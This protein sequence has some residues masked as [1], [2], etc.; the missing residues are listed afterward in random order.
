[1]SQYPERFEVLM[2]GIAGGSSEEIRHA[3]AEM[4]VRWKD[5]PVDALLSLKEKLRRLDMEH[6]E[7]QVDELL[8]SI[9]EKRPGPF[10]EIAT[11]PG[12]PLWRAS[13][14]VLTMV[15]S[16]EYLDLFVSLLPLCRKKG[17]RD[18]V[19]A[20]GSFKG[21]KVVEALGPYLYS[22]DRDTFLEAALALKR[23]GGEKALYHLKGCFEAKRRG[24][25]EDASI[26]EDLIAD[27]GQA[28]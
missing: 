13:V 22:E 27:M 8:I 7:A 23:T 28:A 16:A 2:E 18:I 1:M 17:L 20:I 5:A 19:K 9:A 14:E 3:C 6:R 10:T 12:H 4:R 21:E 25:S 26:I 24:Y 11:E 15:G